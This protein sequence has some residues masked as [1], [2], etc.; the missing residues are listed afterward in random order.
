MDNANLRP[1]LLK[2]RNALHRQK[3]YYVGQ[4]IADLRSRSSAES[5]LPY[6]STSDTASPSC[7]FGQSPHPHPLKAAAN[8]QSRR[9]PAIAS[10]PAYIARLSALDGSRERLSCVPIA[11]RIN[12]NSIYFLFK[13]SFT[14]SM[15]ISFSKYF[16]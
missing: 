13:I 5:L 12:S 16:M 7:R 4:H 2:C 10:L 1:G 3:A 9:L 14:R 6:P 11:T 15:T 8:R